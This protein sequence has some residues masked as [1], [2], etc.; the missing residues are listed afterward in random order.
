MCI[1]YKENIFLESTFV[2]K[3]FCVLIKEFFF[4]STFNPKRVIMFFLENSGTKQFL[5]IKLFNWLKKS[6][7]FCYVQAGSSFICFPF[8]IFSLVVTFSLVLNF[9]KNLDIGIKKKFS[10]YR[11]CMTQLI[12][13]T[14][15]V[16]ILQSMFHWQSSFLIK[17]SFTVYS[18]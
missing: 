1:I 10:Y 14:Y 16:I 6:F 12:R 2:I 11:R 15:L 5:S 13:N 9:W 17:G 3:K 8:L 4:L 18:S 7:H